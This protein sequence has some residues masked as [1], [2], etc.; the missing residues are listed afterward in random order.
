ME[1][2]EVLA[3]LWEVIAKELLQHMHGKE[4]VDRVEIILIMN[5]YNQYKPAQNGSISRQKETGSP[6]DLSVNIEDYFSCRD[7]LIAWVYDRPY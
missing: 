7:F 4:M 5:N 1:E 3:F 6:I 2:L